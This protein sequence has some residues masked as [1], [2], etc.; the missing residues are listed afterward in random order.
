MKRRRSIKDEKIRSEE[1]DAEVTDRTAS[2]S[3]TAAR[4]WSGRVDMM[5]L[6]LGEV[7]GRP[8]VQWVREIFWSS[9]SFDESNRR[10]FLDIIMDSL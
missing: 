4:H 5:P 8:S 2:C 10:L 3:S 7:K 1:K 9:A 6:L